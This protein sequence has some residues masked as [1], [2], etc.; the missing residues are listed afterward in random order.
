MRSK[1][2]GKIGRPGNLPA[3]REERTQ[4][5]G[6]E[7][8]NLPSNERRPDVHGKIGSFVGRRDDY[9]FSLAISWE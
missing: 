8:T 2:P 6:P 1:L 3:F 4:I 7:E 5:P 9:R